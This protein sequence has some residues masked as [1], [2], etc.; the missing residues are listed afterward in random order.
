MCLYQHIWLCVTASA[1]DVYSLFFSPLIFLLPVPAWC[2]LSL[3]IVFKSH[4]LSLI[5]YSAEH[6]EI[7]RFLLSFSHRL[8][9]Y[10][11][12]CLFHYFFLLE[13]SFS[14][15][16]SLSNPSPHSLSRCRNTFKNMLNS[17]YKECL[18]HDFALMKARSLVEI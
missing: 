17:S 4:S 2:I 7:T 9:F 15:S 18:V 8:S 6:P 12:F 5:S 14:V 10:F 3:F 16:A 13:I 1:S 11:F